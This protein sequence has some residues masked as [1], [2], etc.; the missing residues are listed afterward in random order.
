M[1]VWQIPALGV[2]PQLARQPDPIPAEGEALVRVIAAGLNF[3]DLL[4]ID[5]KYQVRVAP[6][7]IP[8]MEFAGVV[9][10]LGSSIG[11]T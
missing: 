2:P 6:P 8:G 9:Q 10:R 1:L 4:M 3:A 5:G 7:Y 11:S